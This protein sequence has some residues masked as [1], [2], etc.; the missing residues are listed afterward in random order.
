MLTSYAIEY[1][2][3][4][5]LQEIVA[6]YNETIDSR[7]VTADL[8]PVTVESRLKWF[9]EHTPDRRPLW[10]VRAGENKGAGS[11]NEYGNSVIAW[12]SFQSFYGRPAYDSTAEISIYIS[13]GYRGKGIGSMLIEQAIA[14][15]PRIGVKTML[16]FV[17]GHNAGSLALLRKHGF[18]QWGLLPQVANLD[19]TERDLVIMGRRAGSN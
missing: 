11:A 15:C 14:S 8:E 19:G 9:A 1:A 12:L 6:I 5:D 4:D 7:A 10:V 13:S 17:F 16:G 2:T 18:E 3:I